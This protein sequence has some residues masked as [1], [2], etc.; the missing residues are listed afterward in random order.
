MKKLSIFLFLLAVISCETP[1]FI[2]PVGPER[3]L[4]LQ[5]RLLTSDSIHTV[6]ASYSAHDSISCAQDLT[7]S[8]YVNGVRVDQTS[9]VNFVK[10]RVAAYRVR[11]NIHPGDSVRVEAEG[12]KEKAWAKVKALNAPPV[13]EVSFE[14]ITKQAPNGQS[15]SF[16]R[17]SI[18]VQD[19]PGQRNWY[20][21][22]C[23]SKQVLEWYAPR[24]PYW[25]EEEGW[26]KEWE[27][28][29]DIWLDN[30][31]DPLLNP[32]GRQTESEG[33]Q[34]NEYNFFTDELFEDKNTV[35]TLEA[36]ANFFFNIYGSYYND[37]V[38]G[39]NYN[40]HRL[41]HTAYFNFENLSR[42]DYLYSRLLEMSHFSLG[43]LNYVGDLFSEDIAL[44]QNVEGGL[45]LVTV[46]TVS[47]ATVDLGI[48]EFEEYY[49]YDIW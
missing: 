26:V 35:L 23:S 30:S 19:E 38:D 29:K 2:D 20:R 6:Y 36:G 5:A 22:T 18:R 4:V 3:M 1:V 16:F 37:Y 47:R 48:T 24:N 40:Q 46:R 9:Y 12:P 43:G 15:S 28:E 10:G 49:N 33:Y 34:D 27:K 44:P 11:A 32:D 13:P 21:M 41:Y 45:G 31:R 39:I 14:K 7:I 25:R 42:E 17:F 8:C